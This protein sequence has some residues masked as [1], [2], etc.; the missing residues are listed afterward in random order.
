M[1]TSSSSL[2]RVYLDNFDQ[3]QKVSRDLAALLEGKPT[4]QTLALRA[5]YEQWGLPRH[6]KKEVVAQT[7]AEV[8]GAIVDGK[9]GKAWPKPQ[10][11]GIYVALALELLRRG[12]ATQREMQV[13]AGGFVYF[14]MFRR[15]L[16]CALN[17]IWTFI[18]GFKKLPPVV[19]LGIPDLVRLELVR[20]CSLFPL[21]RM[22]FRVGFSPVVSATDASDLR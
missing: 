10:K 16:L 12:V 14:A 19:R 4:A 3:L 17:S 22:D 15:P 21:A 2:Y 13:V 20:F 11:I 5:S 1:H 6:P 18:E 8:Q 7:K 9:A